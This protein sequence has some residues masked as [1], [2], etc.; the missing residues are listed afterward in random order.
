MDAA[1][2]LLMKYKLMTITLTEACAEIGIAVG[3]AHNKI[4]AGTL[5][6]PTYIKGKSRAVD[7]RDLGKYIDDQ[8]E[9]ARRVF[10]TQ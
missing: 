9:R 7:V 8:R 10:E 3:T 6:F 4:S 2:Y 5:G 1:M